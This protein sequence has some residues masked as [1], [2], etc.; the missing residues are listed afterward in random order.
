M[1][2]IV[3]AATPTS[4]WQYFTEFKDLVMY[5]TKL[6]PKH[7]HSEYIYGD[8]NRKDIIF[9]T[10]VHID[11]MQ[12]LGKLIV[13]GWIETLRIPVCILLRAM[14]YEYDLFRS[15]AYNFQICVPRITYCH[16]RRRFKYFYYEWYIPMDMIGG[17]DWDIYFYGPSTQIWQ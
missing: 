7:I 16:S 17:M 14:S 2:F 9:Y 12:V 6:E 13:R 11:H 1:D 8:C 4:A 3:I 5:G 10:H 15:T